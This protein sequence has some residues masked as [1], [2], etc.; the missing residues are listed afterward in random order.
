MSTK[1]QMLASLRQA[2]NTT[3]RPLA[4]STY[5]QRAGFAGPEP[6]E[7]IKAFGSWNAALKAAGLPYHGPA[8]RKPRPSRAQMEAPRQATPPRVRR[9]Y[10]PDAKPLMLAAVQRIDFQKKMRTARRDQSISNKTLSELVTA[11]LGRKITASSLQALQSGHRNL[12]EDLA[13]AIAESLGFAYTP[14][15]QPAPQTTEQKD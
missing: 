3:C 8:N 13:I 11:R 2:A 12:R 15:Q 1:T 5:S 4:Q 14:L 9:T 10:S 6:S 7:I